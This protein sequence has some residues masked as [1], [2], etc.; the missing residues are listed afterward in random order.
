[1]STDKM[2]LKKGDFASGKRPSEFSS[3]EN[4]IDIPEALR[5]FKREAR[6]I[7]TKGLSSPEAKALFRKAAKAVCQ[8]RNIMPAV[9]IGLLL[10]L[11]ATALSP[12]LLALQYP[13]GLATLAVVG[14]LAAT[15]PMLG[16][17]VHDYSKKGPGF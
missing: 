15:R 2:T 11:G 1:M 16:A 6:V 17:G 8:R 7:A 14:Y 10:G 4:P 3:D 13:I 9:A 5:S 12:A